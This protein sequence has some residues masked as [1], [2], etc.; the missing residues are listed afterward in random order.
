LHTGFTPLGSMTPDRINMMK[1]D[2][3]IEE[4]NK[5]LTDEELD[6]LLPTEGYEV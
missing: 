3:D 5:P 2:K 6:Q 4:R 1:L